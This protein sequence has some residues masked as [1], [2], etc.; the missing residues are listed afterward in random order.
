[1]TRYEYKVVPAPVQGRKA[2]GVKGTA[3]RFAH[4][5]ETLMNELGAE[6][7]EYVRAD[8]LPC[9]ERTGLTGRTT[10]YQ[11]MLVFRRPLGAAEDEAAPA[12]SGLLAAPLPEEGGEAR[13]EWRAPLAATAAEAG[14]HREPPLTRGAPD[15][16][17]GATAGATGRPSDTSEAARAAAAALRTY[18]AGSPRG[19]SGDDDDGARGRGGGLAAE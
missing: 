14:H 11:N 19:A 18:R 2:R 7:W 4:A 12:I 5:L 3:G 8:T 1:M 16:S 9:E 6:G 17:D 13:P 10:T 15:A